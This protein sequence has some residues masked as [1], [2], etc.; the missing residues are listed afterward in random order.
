MTRRKK[1]SN[2][3]ADV[4]EILALI[5]IGR[6]VFR[7]HR[8]T[9]P[10]LRAAKFVVPVLVVVVI[11][12]RRSKSEAPPIS[13]APPPPPP[14]APAPTTETERALAEEKGETP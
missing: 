10:V 7:V 5:R 12:R 11:L 2:L 14:P 4:A 3:I 8:R 13:S 6:R 9:R 1:R